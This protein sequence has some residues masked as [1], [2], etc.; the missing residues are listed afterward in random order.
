MAPREQKR[1]LA[2]CGEW[3]TKTVFIPD[4]RTAKPTQ[5]IQNVLSQ[6]SSGSLLCK[7][8]NGQKRII[9]TN[10]QPETQRTFRLWEEVAASWTT[11]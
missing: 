11:N 1:F 9:I 5:K 4:S 2:E 6:A 3:N 8:Q 7:K 10:M